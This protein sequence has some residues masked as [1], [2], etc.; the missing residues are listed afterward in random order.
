MPGWNASEAPER[1]PRTPEE[2]LDRAEGRAREHLLGEALRI[3]E[4]LRRGFEPGGWVRRHPVLATAAAATLG[5]VAVPLALAA[6][7]SPRS[8]MRMARQLLVRLGPRTGFSEAA[9]VVD[10][11]R[12]TVLG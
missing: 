4:E 5:A 7:R 10:R 9:A 11:L 6:L 1:R 2:V 3:E 8:S 12:D